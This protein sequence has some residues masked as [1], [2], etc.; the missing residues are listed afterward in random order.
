MKIKI[1]KEI[2]KKEL[3][4]IVRDK[5]S[6]IR[7]I[8]TP[9]IIPLF[10][11]FMSYLYG[12][13]EDVFIG[14]SYKVGY[15]YTLSTV[16]KTLISNTTL[17]MVHYDTLD[18]MKKAYEDKEIVAYIDLVSE[19]KYDVYY[20]QSD[21]S[22]SSIAGT[23]AYSYLQA[24]NSYLGENYLIGEDIDLNKVHNQLTI[25]TKE[26]SSGSSFMVNMIVSFA[27]TYCLM[28]V[29][30]AAIYGATDSVAGEKERGTL[31]TMLTFPVSNFDIMAGKFLA[32]L[33]SCTITAIFSLSLSFGS[34]YISSQIFEIYKTV[35]LNVSIVSMLLTILTLF[36]GCIICSGLCI[37]ITSFCN[38]FKEA[39]EALSPLSFLTIIPMFLS[40]MGIE[41]AWWAYLIPICGQ[42]I[43]LDDLI[44]D[45]FKVLNLVVLLIS[46]VIFS[47]ILLTYI[48]K[49]YKSEKAIFGG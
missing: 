39:Q 32:I 23:M 18:D 38:T 21:A 13:V 34:I 47:I 46:S 42:G 37:A 12:E 9:F 5:K 27:M 33:I 35:T 16:E 6:L 7:L 11:F 19:N 15:N 24:Y 17:E 36:T 20:N 48:A 26:L 41:N 30:L 40:M 10:V 31:E 8:A 25:E 22:D 49:R 14:D 1:V 2:I 45:K 4:T 44:Y 29:M 43:M 3:R 28:I